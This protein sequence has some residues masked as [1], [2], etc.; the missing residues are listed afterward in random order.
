M[1]NERIF[2]TGG[3]GFIG[4]NLV[5]YF[6]DRGNCNI[7]VYDNLSSCT[8]ENLERAVKDSR[9]EGEV[10]FIE[11]D[12]LD[13]TKLNRAVKGHTAVIHL[14]AHTRVIE[15]LE[16]PGENFEINSKG[17]FNILEASRKNKVKK[18]IFASSNASLGEQISPIN[19]KMVPRPL[20]PYG[21]T[22]LFGEALCCAY[23][24]SYGLK[25][26]SLRFA[27]AYGP[28]SEH[29]TSVVARFIKRV[30]E[31]K[32][33]EIYGD[34]NQTRD[35]I[36]AKDICRAVYLSLNYDQSNYNIW[37]EVFQIGTGKETKIKDLAD[38]LRENITAKK[39][40]LYFIKPRK[41]EI[42]R[43]FSHI[44]K[45]RKI[46]GFSPSVKDILKTPHLE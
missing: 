45:A 3:A 37:G 23:F 39:S 5:K 38:M 31:G 1:K 9:Q 30:K 46:L 4:A 28:Y 20:S 36:H 2:I 18:F 8:K 26:V 32:P 17:V 12:I 42:R 34:G 24:H 6:L 14:A 41:G 13:F 11:G 21:A 19:E 29:K 33:L 16:N 25:T 7:T 35:F 40:K 43:N 15:S 22:K 27:N 44:D 10:R